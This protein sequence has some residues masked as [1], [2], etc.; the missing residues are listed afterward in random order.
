MSNFDNDDMEELMRVPN[1][2]NC[3]VN[4]VLYHLGSCGVEYALLP[5]LK[6][7]NIPLMAYCPLAQAGNLREGTESRVSGYP[8]KA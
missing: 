4:Q 3:A 5:W 8:G 7:H 2:R 1:G 6:E